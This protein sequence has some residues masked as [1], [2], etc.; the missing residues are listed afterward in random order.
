ML[1]VIGSVSLARAKS[2]PLQLNQASVFWEVFVGSSCNSRSFDS[3]FQLSPAFK[4]NQN[5]QR[6]WYTPELAFA[7]VA[8]KIA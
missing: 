3:E 5:R 8:G 4:M 6:C 1:K 7:V 2:A